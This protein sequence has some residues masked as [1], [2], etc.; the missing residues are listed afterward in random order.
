M[1]G[2]GLCLLSH[3]PHNSKLCDRL[4]GHSKPCDQPCSIYKPC[5][6]PCGHSKLC[7][8]PCGHSKP[9]DQPC[10]HSFAVPGLAAT[11]TPVTGPWA[12][13]GS[14][15]ELQPVIPTHKTRRQ[16]NGCKSACL[17]RKGT[18]TQTRKEGKDE[19]GYSEVRP[20]WEQEDK[21]E[22]TE[23]VTAQSLYQSELQYV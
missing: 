15:P 3:N 9:C 23:A 4:C 5:D 22:D 16:K 17:V 8:P 18:P 11:P 21:K 7:H 19:A 10:S 1:L 13:P 20:S 12:R 2:P 14:Q 6:R